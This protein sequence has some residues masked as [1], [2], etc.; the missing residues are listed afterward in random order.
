MPGGICFSTVWD[1]EVTCAVAVRISTLDRKKIFTTP[2][3]F[4]DWLSICSISLTFEVSWR[5]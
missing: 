3:P 5:S 2:T 1:T 4:K